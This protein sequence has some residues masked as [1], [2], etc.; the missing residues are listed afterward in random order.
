[1]DQNNDFD[2][3]QPIN[4]NT[5][6]STKE[7]NITEIY[8]GSNTQIERNIFNNKQDYINVNEELNIKDIKDE[9]FNFSESKKIFFKFRFEIR[10]I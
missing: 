7:S 6:K 1:M 5:H 9:I 4:I 3:N 8:S 2:V 10:G